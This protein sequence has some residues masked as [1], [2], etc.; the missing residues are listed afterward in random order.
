MLS[1]ETKRVGRHRPLVYF[2]VVF[3]IGILLQF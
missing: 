2:A 1:G 3:F